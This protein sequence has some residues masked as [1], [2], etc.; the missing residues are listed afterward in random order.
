MNKGSI[1]AKC[2]KTANTKLFKPSCPK[3]CKTVLQIYSKTPMVS[4]AEGSDMPACRVTSNKIG[5]K[6]I[7]GG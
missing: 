5:A 1:V 4:G 7:W 3:N 6:S 2:K